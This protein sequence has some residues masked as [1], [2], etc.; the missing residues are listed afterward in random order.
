MPQIRPPGRVDDTPS[1]EEQFLDLL[2]A[3]DEL[4]RVEFDAIIAA[5]WPGPPPN[6]PHRRVGGGPDPGGKRRYRAAATGG[7][8]PGWR[9]KVGGSARQRSPPAE[10]HEKTDK[11]ERKAGDRQ[12]VIDSFE[13]TVRPARTFH[14]WASDRQTGDAGAA[15]A[16]NSGGPDET[17]AFHRGPGLAAAG[18]TATT[19]PPLDHDD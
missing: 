13:V 4:L 3:D 11:R 6:L 1:T 7:P 15:S 12:H 14:P 16:P 2:L 10:D 9:P 19:D 17:V 18:T 8:G 5:E